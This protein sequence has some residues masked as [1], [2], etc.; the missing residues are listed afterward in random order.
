MPKD[1][2]LKEIFVKIPNIM[3]SILSLILVLRI[4]KINKKR[5]SY[6]LVL[7]FP[8]NEQFHPFVYGSI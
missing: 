4:K 7:E 5:R 2:K 3:P 8:K 6:D 1:S